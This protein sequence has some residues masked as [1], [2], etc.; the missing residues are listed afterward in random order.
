MAKL[1]ERALALRSQFVKG[2]MMLVLGLLGIGIGI[3]TGQPF[4]KQS[5]GSIPTF[6][7]IHP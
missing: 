2:S 6:G 7:T 4:W 3:K 1:T 5:V